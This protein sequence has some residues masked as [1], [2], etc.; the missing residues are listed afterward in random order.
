MPTFDLVGEP[1]QFEGQRGRFLI[2]PGDGAQFDK[3]IRITLEISEVGDGNVIAPGQ[4]GRRTVA[5]PPGQQRVILYVDTVDDK[6]HDGDTR[7]RA[8]MIPG[9]DYGVS[10]YGYHEA[11]IAVI[12]D[13]IPVIN[14]EAGPNINEGG[15]ARFNLRASPTPIVPL[16]VNVDV[17]ASGGDFAASG[18]TGRKTVSI[19]TNGRGTLEVATESD[20][21]D[22]DDGIITATLQTGDYQV[23]A[24]RSARVAVS[25]GGT[26]TPSVSISGP[27]SIAEGETIT[28]TLTASPAPVTP[29]DVSVTLTESGSFA[30]NNEIRNRTVNIGTGGTATFTVATENDRT[31]EADGAITASL[32]KASGYLL[33]SPATAAVT[34]R[35]TTPAV[36]IA[37][38]PAIFEGGE[39]SFTLTVTPRL[40][41]SLEV[42]VRVSDSGEFVDSGDTGD[43]FFTIPASGT[44]TFTVSTFDDSTLETNGAITATVRSG[45]GYGPGTAATASVRVTDSTPRVSIA[46]GAAVIE[47]DDAVFTLTAAPAPPP[48]SLLT[49]YVEV[50]DSGS[51]ANVGETG[52]RSVDIDDTGT[53]TLRVPTEDDDVDE[54]QEQGTITARIVADS[55]PAYYGIRAPVAATVHVND[56]DVASKPL[57]KVSIGDAQPIQENADFRK[58]DFLEFP[59][60]LDVTGAFV[61]TVYF[62]VRATTET[63]TTA[64]ATDGKDFKFNRAVYSQ[65]VSFTSTTGQTEKMIRFEVLDDDEYEEKPETFEVVIT[66]VVGAEIADGRAT[67]TILP[68]PAD[69]P[70]NM[71]VVAIE[72]PSGPLTEGDRAVFTIKADPAPRHDIEVTLTVRDDGASDFLEAADEGTRTITIYGLDEF[73][74]EAYKGVSARNIRIRTV[75][76]LDREANG[77]IAVTVEPDPDRDADGVYDV[78]SQSY[79]AVVQVED[80]ERA[81]PVISIAGGPKVTEGGA[82]TFTLTADPAPQKDLVVTVFVQDDGGDFIADENEVSRTVT[83]DAVSDGAFSRRRQATASF[84]V[85]TVDDAI[86]ES[87]ANIRAVIELDSGD[88][89]DVSQ[90]TYEAVVEIED[91]ERGTPLVTIEAGAAVTEGGA[92]SFTLNAVPAPEQDLDVLVT[93]SSAAGGLFLADGDIGDRTITIPGVSEADFA[94]RRDTSMSFTVDT[95]DDAQIED[96]GGVQVYINSADS[97]DTNEN[98]DATVPVQDNDTP[99]ISVSAPTGQILEG[100]PLVFTLNIDPVSSSELVVDVDITAPNNDYVDTSGTRG[101]GLRALTIPANAAT[102]TVQVDTVDD[103]AVEGSAGTVTVTVQEGGGYQPAI[104]PGNSATASVIDNDDILTVS[105]HDT[106]AREGEK[107][108]FRVT[109]SKPTTGW[110]QVHVSTHVTNTRN[111]EGKA[112]SRDYNSAY[113]A[114]HFNPGEV[115]KTFEVRTIDDS[116][117]DP[118]EFLLAE[119]GY[120]GEHS[121]RIGGTRTRLTVARKTARGTIRNSD[122]LPAAWLAR[123]GRAVAEQAIDGITDRLADRRETMDDPDAM[124]PGQRSTFSGFGAGNAGP[125]GLGGPG[126]PG[127]LGIPGAGGSMPGFAT[128]QAPGGSAFAHPQSGGLGYGA[129]NG[130]GL[131]PGL[132][133]SDHAENRNRDIRFSHTGRRDDFG[134]SL[135]FWGRAMQSRFEGRDDGLSL[136]GETNS[137]LVGADYA[138]G[139]WLAGIALTRSEGIGGFRADASNAG[140]AGNEGNN[141]GEMSATLTAAIPYASYQFSES[142]D[143]WGAVGQGLGEATLRPSKDELYQLDTRWSMAAAGL[144]GEMLRFDSGAELAIVSDALW[145]RTTSD[146]TRGVAAAEAETSRL[147]LGLE[148]SYPIRFA[149]GGEIVPRLEAGVRH[150]GGDAE[151]GFGVEIGGGL[152]WREPRLGLQV[153]V[154]GRRL[155]THEQAAFAD[156]GFSASIGFDPRPASD[157]GLSLNLRQDFGARSSGGLNALFNQPRLL[158]GGG[159]DSDQAR[160]SAEAAYGLPAFGGRFVGSP[161]LGYGA[162]AFGRDVSV[163]WRLAP[164]EDGP[165]LSLGILLL[166]RQAVAAPTE[167]GYGFE[168]TARW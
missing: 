23:G 21:I 163:G 72:G 9:S 149:G 141:G 28:F 89:Y 47:G 68:D 127:V 64:P 125:G 36:N 168:F 123:F 8:V 87:D 44:H 20:A 32:A 135:A 49:V 143:V 22:E 115:E 84:T 98:Y 122:P 3:T 138:R 48:P 85:E 6:A 46:G 99:T 90:D 2:F 167:H 148:G 86:F 92:A 81:K 12:D 120:A 31:A 24:K 108:R 132:P 65:T 133:Y 67:G 156:Q 145:T 121:Q 103:D 25:D 128:N 126:G 97:Y 43:R 29:V 79:E 119:I 75:D 164:A 117:D 95:V 114:L 39:A 52:R 151:T 55:A 152:A 14:V 1:R 111:Y 77:N 160:W 63:D 112:T 70:R 54:N 158:P 53:G 101:T 104:A 153:D 80:N 7:L 144:R 61:V 131:N 116:I 13:D 42:N 5:F 10:K 155:V 129:R 18:A 74:F 37:A 66:R 78:D 165:D 166:R 137:A 110:V 147:R 105:I 106:E 51:F 57:P 146:Q 40:T 83:I 60:T 113:S 15:T 118:D 30:A 94:K 45:T 16:T 27:G 56:N 34:V 91:N 76:D 59:V 161:H 109:L 107:L 50:S 154:E 17:A 41:S 82:A 134:G 88:D 159:F 124:E 96:S 93:I 150:D 11:E 73:E 157:Y 69:A 58:R 71:P 62:E 19:G 140:S 26:P 4:A 130:G 35:D 136:D 100:Q 33:G 142:F 102:A 38:G 162:T 139:R